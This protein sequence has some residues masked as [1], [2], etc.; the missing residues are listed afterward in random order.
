MDDPLL[1]KTAAKRR[2]TVLDAWGCS[3]SCHA[4]A[5]LRVSEIQVKYV[6]AI[7]NMHERPQIPYA[8]QGWGEQGKGL[9][10]CRGT[11]LRT[12]AV[13]HLRPL[14]TKMVHI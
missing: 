14:S 12:S 3:K 7:S 4:K 10:H 11:T 6:Y 5:K 1:Q 13:W 8:G 2:R 9:V